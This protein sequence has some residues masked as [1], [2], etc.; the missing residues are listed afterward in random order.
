MNEQLIPRLQGGYAGIGVDDEQS[1]RPFA[2]LLQL[3]ERRP[4]H[5][6]LKVE[7]RG[8]IVWRLDVGGQDRREPLWHEM[9]LSR[10]SE[11]IG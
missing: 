5:A 2:P 7:G 10:T 8:K 6:I 11:R 3:L 1:F 4:Q 9:L